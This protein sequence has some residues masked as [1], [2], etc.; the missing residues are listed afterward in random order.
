[1]DRSTWNKSVTF[2]EKIFNQNFHF[3]IYIYNGIDDETYLM[4]KSFWCFCEINHCVK[5]VCIRSFSVSYFPALGLNTERYSVSPCLQSACG[6]IGTR[7]TPN[8]DTFHVFTQCKRQINLF[9][10]TIFHESK[11]VENS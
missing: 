11:G 5:S 7:K 8:M 9:H 1:M 4:M 2:R 10:K 3:S 6:K